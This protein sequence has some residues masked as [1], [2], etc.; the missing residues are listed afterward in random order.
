MFFT[1]QLPFLSPNQQW[2]NTEGNS[3]TNPNPKKAN[4]GLILS[5][6]QYQSYSLCL[7]SILFLE[8][9]CVHNWMPVFSKGFL[10]VH[11]WRISDQTQQLWAMCGRVITGIVSSQMAACRSNCT[12]MTFRSFSNYRSFQMGFSYSCAAADKISTDIAHS[13]VP[14]QWQSFLWKFS[15]Q[16]ST[17]NL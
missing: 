15:H 3:K 1:G 8:Y 9:C 5:Y 2:L 4:N 17:V 10:F 7:H 14:P 16:D 12:V 11:I 13:T 6:R